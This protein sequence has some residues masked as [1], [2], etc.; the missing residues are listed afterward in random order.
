M[1]YS[2]DDF[3]VLNKN[4][5]GATFDEERIPS[6][7]DVLACAFDQGASGYALTWEN[8]SDK[9]KVSILKHQKESM[10]NRIANLCDRYQA[11]YFLPFAGHCRL[12]L[13]AHAKYAVM[14][15]HTSFDEIE[16]ILEQNTNT[17]LLNL[18]PGEFYD[19]MEPV[20]KVD[21]QQSTVENTVFTPESEIS[22]FTNLSSFKIYCLDSKFQELKALK[23]IFN[24]ESVLVKIRIGNCYVFSVD[25]RDSDSI[26]DIVVEVEFPEYIRRI[27]CDEGLNWD[28]IAI[29]YWGKWSR[30][31]TSYPSNFMRALQT[32]T[33][34]LRIYPVKECT[35]IRE[36]KIL[37]MNIASL[38][39]EHSELALRI[40]NR[41]GLPCVGCFYSPGE[42]LRTA[43]SRHR[44]PIGTQ[45]RLVKE[46]K[47]L[48]NL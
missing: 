39:E 44:L 33:D 26:D 27:I 3:Y 46:L 15:P 9:R 6:S 35:E 43:I 42:S 32:G 38:I 14:I 23:N 5:A 40:L 2:F 10:L 19:F 8:L 4:D 17:Q 13:K 37:N 30:S 25:L 1:L 12:N 11:L 20:I 31:S 48:I 18:Y 28:R 22:E 41:S 29:G 34:F 21:S 47:E 16:F 45:A 24:I 7:I 36:D